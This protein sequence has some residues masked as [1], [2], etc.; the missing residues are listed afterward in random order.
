MSECCQS[1]SAGMVSYHKASLKLPTAHYVRARFWASGRCSLTRRSPGRAADR[2]VLH[3]G[4]FTVWPASPRLHNPC[5][6]PAVRSCGG[7]SA[8]A[9]QPTGCCA[10]ACH[11]KRVAQ[12]AGSMCKW[13]TAL[14]V[15]GRFLEHQ[16]SLTACM[17]ST[18]LMR[19]HQLSS[20]AVKRQLEKAGTSPSQMGLQERRQS[21]MCPF[22]GQHLGMTALPGSRLL[23]QST[24]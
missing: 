10:G 2:V 6:A 21:P 17:L 3:V 24:H 19:L 1:C 15:V 13:D 12:R 9:S 18:C 23:R 14:E 16:E 22:H 8:C 5:E 4:A 20:L 7:G 11:Q